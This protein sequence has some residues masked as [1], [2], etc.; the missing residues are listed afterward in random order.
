LPVAVR[1]LKIKQPPDNKKYVYFAAAVALMA[2][3]NLLPLPQ[4]LESAGGLVNLTTQGKDALSVLGFVIILWFSEAM[5][6]PVTALFGLLLAFLFSLASFDDLV[7][8]GF[9]SSITVFLSA[10]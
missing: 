3:I 10:C 9:G 2:A 7:A 6:F 1:K 4:P 8:Y 5:P